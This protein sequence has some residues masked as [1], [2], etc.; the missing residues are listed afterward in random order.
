MGNP[1][2]DVQQTAAVPAIKFVR[3]LG[4]L[5]PEQMHKVEVVLAQV[6]GLKLAIG[7]P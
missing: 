6:P 1:G 2:F 3:R 4:S 5:N 7:P